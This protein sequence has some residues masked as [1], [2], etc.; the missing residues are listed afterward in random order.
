MLRGFES[1]YVQ[2]YI[3]TCKFESIFFISVNKKTMIFTEKEC[4]I[5]VIFFMVFPILWHLLSMIEIWGDA[6]KEM[7]I[8]EAI[9]E[10]QRYGLE[11]VDGVYPKFHEFR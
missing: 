5:F 8:K 1:H 11:E 2:I 7:T 3:Y 10:L 6:K 4:Y 9:K